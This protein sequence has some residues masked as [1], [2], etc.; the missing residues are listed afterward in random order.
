MSTNKWLKQLTAYEDT[1]NFEYDAF[2]PENCIYTPSP[3][4]NWIFANKSHG[5]PLGSTVLMYSS[6]KAGKSLMMQGII[7][8]LHQS[9]PEAIA[10]VFNTEMRGK[11]QKD[12]FKTIDKDRMVI[13]DSNRPE[14]VFDRFERDIVP[15]IQDGMPLKVVC[16]DSLTAIGGTKSLSGD[17]SVNDHL[18]GDHALTINKGL[19]KI[20]PYCKKYNITL[21]M[22]SQIRA[23]V[24]ASNPH[25]PKEKM[26]ESWK[27]QHT[28]EY[29]ISIRRAT[30]ADD[31]TDLEGNKFEEEGIKDARGTKDQTGHK[32]YFKMEQSSIGT[33]GRAGVTTVDYRHG[34][35]NQ[36]EEVFELGK[37][38]NIIK[39]LG[40][41]SYEVY[42]EKIRGKA[43][44]A[45]RIKEDKDLYNRILEDVKKLDSER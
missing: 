21:I 27:V 22:S 38:T 24:D 23:N 8:Q 34:F 35:I 26:A 13:Y 39:N 12:L 41:G 20:V 43:E 9:D 40:A 15:M 18:V 2:A 45:R 29:F 31:K 17:R 16:I 6:A 4:V 32:I 7:G 10:I 5:I 3:Y 36:H 19:D 11:F 30:A 28:A 37:N 33:A 25:A 44:V 1:V 42:G 14:D